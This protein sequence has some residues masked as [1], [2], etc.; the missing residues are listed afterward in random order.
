MTKKNEHLTRKVILGYASLIV[1]AAI[2]VLYIFNLVS[3]M[4]GNRNSDDTTMEKIY[5][6]T[7]VLS[8]L[9]EGETYT[10][11]T[12]DPQ[13][14]FEKFNEVMN[15]VHIQM[16]SLRLLDTDNGGKIDTI[17]L[18]IEEKRNNTQLLLEAMLEMK[19]VFAKSIAKEMAT[20]REQSKE[21]EIS[22]Q[23][24]NSQD[25]LVTQRGKKGFFKRLAEAFVPTKEDTTIRVNTT[26]R[27]KTD[28]LVNAYDPSKEITNALLK[29][30]KNIALEREQ[31]TQVLINRTNELHQNNNIITNEIN[32]VLVA[33][34]EKEIQK[35]QE[36]EM[37]KQT[38]VHSASR[39][40][41][42]ISIIAIII[43]L[44]FLSLTIR[45]IWQSRYYRDQL[46]KAKL[47]AE[48][49][50]QSREKLMLT[51]SH[52]IRSP[53]S[54][55]LGYIEL[56]RKNKPDETQ[57]EYLENMNASSKHIL[58]LVNDLLDFHRLESGKMDIH[59]TPFIIHTLFWEIY[60][61]F[62]PLA[63]A[64]RLRF[65]MSIENVSHTQAYQG[66]T[67]RIR[68]IVGNLLSNAI[69]F[70]PKG[71]IWMNISINQ[72]DEGPTL[73]ISVKDEGPGIPA[74]E[75]KTIFGE[76][77]RL[78]EAKK[79]EGFGLG[80]SITGKLLSLMA[81]QITLQSTEGEGSE[82][83]VTLPL[84]L[85]DEE[86]ANEPSARE[87]AKL[88]IPADRNINF[89]VVDDDP[90]QIRLTENLLRQNKV[91]VI[92]IT[93]PI[94]AEGLLAQASF[95]IILTDIQMPGLTGYELLNHIR[96]SG[97]PGADTIPIIALSAS[98]EEDATHYIK[99]GF[100]GF[101]S[102]P[103][104][105]D[106]LITLVNK[107]LA[108]NLTPV[109][110]A[111]LTSFAEN[112]KEASTSI[113]Q[114][115]AEETEKNL[116]LLKKALPEKDKDQVSKIAHKLIP[117]LKMLEAHTLVDQLRLLERNELSTPKWEQT[118]E[119][120]IKQLSSIIAQIK[121]MLQ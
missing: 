32:R 50:L 85:S 28:S 112:D 42:S 87:E 39:H 59:P 101:L 93:D 99:A 46:E 72:T 83:T 64:K 107:L 51:I 7:N 74:E 120:M 16:D 1:I 17:N 114:T 33:I 69:K 89:L 78:N 111:S 19:N 35:L 40:L 108:A 15:Q 103:F 34:E 77:T 113:L 76:F 73:I 94:L 30:Q 96:T 10:Q 115:F 13:T 102:K 92:P 110:I 4:A 119:E 58:S 62:K 105:S 29:V 8:L 91:N 95:D 67:V 68:Q 21:L 90:I 47:Y 81:G 9:Y 116:L 52:D 104:T 36:E 63:D 48:N 97:I 27:T 117:L 11:F 18:L 66:D 61:G 71:N 80:L 82:F 84:Q 109:N 22:K 121:K 20:P 41:A 43:F 106:A 98:A 37:L 2:A 49:L 70:T 54:S 60:A 65:H 31:L 56:L 57:Q 25:T 24:E 5:L 26:N 6:I 38:M 3:K 44:F 118:V 45:D 53:L 75:Q 23:E 79:T 14:E 55:I 86:S 12:I 100:T 88:N